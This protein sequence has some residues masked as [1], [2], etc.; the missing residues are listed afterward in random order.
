MTVVTSVENLRLKFPGSNSLL[1]RDFS[2]SVQ[3]GEKVLIVGPSG[4]G[5]STL[6]QVLTG[7]I[8]D[9]IEVPIKTDNV[10]TP[11]S[12]GFLFQDPDTQF[13]M[14][15]V[16]E[17]LAFVL[18]N[19]QIPREQ[20]EERIKANLD[21]VGLS[22]EDIHTSIQTLSGGMKQRLAIASVLALQ[23]EVLFLDEPTAL[24]DPEGTDEVWK[25]IKHIGEDKT[26]IIVEHNIEKI[27]DFVDRVIL[28]NEHGK[29]I[30]DGTKDYIFKY[31]TDTLREHGIWYPGVW[32]DYLAN[33]SL[34][35]TYH[36]E[37]DSH[38]ERIC[39]SEFTG[40][41]RKE[42]KIEV[43]KADIHSK[44]WIAIIG[45]NGAGKSTLL[46]ALMKL[47]KTKGLY[48]INGQ[49][50]NKVDEVTKHLSFVFQNPEFQFISN[51]VY[52][53]ITYS[54]SQENWNQK[55][56]DKRVEECL[57]VYNLSKVKTN[58][59][60]QLSLG[61]K[62]RLSVAS[63]MVRQQPF[64]L[65]DEPTFGQ[66]AR[67]TF[68]ILEQLEAIRL[69]GSTIL[70]VTHDMKIVEN[71]AT[72]VWEIREGK[73][74]E[75]CTPNEWIKRSANSLKITDEGRSNDNGVK[76]SSNLVTQN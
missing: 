54:L 9:S 39:L 71:F 26:L 51:S 31:Y 6:L 28:L 58:H 12:W 5:K 59:P 62:R 57:D 19:L 41:R 15:Y 24:L 70:M 38:Q 66:D 14:P 72:R 10:T 74:V 76:L 20:M 55:E 11:S 8:P 47:I 1:F 53:E 36:E 42:K 35:Q 33:S 60:Y 44:E 61:Q 49:Q 30:A 46:H 50:Y 67:N 65:L 29:L 3:K 16:D 37:K 68:D 43:R 63:A 69:Q 23:P 27:V 22:F 45:E 13:C 32:D 75:D 48:K 56:I 7:L 40:F 52:D 25:T 2:L 34:K 4:S 17:E 64:L 18:E 21:Q 73:L